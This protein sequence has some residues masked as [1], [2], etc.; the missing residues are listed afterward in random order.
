MKPERIFSL[1]LISIF[2]N[3][4]SVVSFAMISGIGNGTYWVRINPSIWIFAPFA[5]IGVVSVYR[6]P[7]RNKNHSGGE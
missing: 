3:T 1:L 6:K 7:N 5:M 4:V 2:L